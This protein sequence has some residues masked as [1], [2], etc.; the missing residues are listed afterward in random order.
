MAA[1]PSIRYADARLGLLNGPAWETARSNVCRSLG[2]SLSAEETINMLSHQLDET[3]RTVANNLPSNPG[4]RLEKVDGK[5][6]LIVSALDKLEEPPSLVRLREAVN[7]RLPRVDLPE[8]L[9][10]IAIRIWWR[11]CAVIFLITNAFERYL[12]SP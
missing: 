2:S 5:D 12:R 1:A 10:E 6:E 7:A 8:V 3:Y 9:L 4:A 11:S